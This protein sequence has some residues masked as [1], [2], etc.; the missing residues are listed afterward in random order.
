MA[1]VYVYEPQYKNA[2]WFDD[3]AR[4]KSSWFDRDIIDDVITTLVMFEVSLFVDDDDVFFVPPPITVE[5]FPELF[6]DKDLFFVPMALRA[7]NHPNAY[8]KNEI[9]R[10]R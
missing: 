4:V 10:V 7:L 1:L 9:R 3:S 6:L 8:L 2:G 5:V